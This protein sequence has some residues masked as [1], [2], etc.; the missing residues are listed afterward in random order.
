M[1]RLKTVH[2]VVNAA[3]DG[4]PFEDSAVIAINC[5]PEAMSQHLQQGRR[6]AYRLLRQPRTPRKDGWQQKT[7]QL[8]IL[9]IQISINERME[10]TVL[11]LRWDRRLAAMVKISAAVQGCAREGI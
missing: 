8:P 2:R 7:A 9:G 10:L 4:G 5:L 1:W 11:V 3:D 6:N